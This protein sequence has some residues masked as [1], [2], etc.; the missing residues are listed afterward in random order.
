MNYTKKNNCAYNGMHYE[1]IQ[2]QTVGELINAGFG[3]KRRTCSL[4][5]RRSQIDYLPLP[6]IE[7]N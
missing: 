5:H 1:I 2:P 3:C 7:A 4:N 6:Y